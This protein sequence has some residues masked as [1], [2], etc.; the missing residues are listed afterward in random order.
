MMAHDDATTERLAPTRR[1]FLARLCASGAALTLPLLAQTSCNDGPVDPTERASI[2]LS[3]DA[4]VLNYFYAI[5]QLQSDFWTRL[6]VNR[7][8]GITTAESSAFNAMA[9][10]ATNHRNWLQAFVTSGR[11]TDVM[12]FNFADSVNFAVRASATAAGLTIEDAASQAYAGGIKYLSSSANILLA[13]KMASVAARH[14]ATIRDFIAIAAG[15]TSR[16][17]FA[18]DDI[19]G[20]TG[21]EIIRTPDE[22]ISTISKFYHTTLTVRNA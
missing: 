8:P 19:V 15:G 1:G 9:N 10:H 18:G 21:V 4:G 2:D 13:S 3:T 7:F 17:S 12:T 6:G 20:P 14:S 16:A 22:I 11:V 5:A